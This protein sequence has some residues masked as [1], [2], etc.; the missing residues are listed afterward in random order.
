MFG[1]GGGE[2]ILILFVVLMLFGS[3]K[4]P[5]IARTM[6]KAMAQLKNATNDIKSEITKGADANGLNTKSITDFTGNI[7]QE[8]NKAKDNLLK[9][10]S[11]IVETPKAETPQSEG[12]IKRES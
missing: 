11:P 5:D 8:I 9:D 7:T 6:G 1:I 2:L 4:I 12:P 10:A 3:D